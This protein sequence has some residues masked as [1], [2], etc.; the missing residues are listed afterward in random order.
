MISLAPLQVLLFRHPDDDEL[1]PFENA[2]VRAFQ[3][4]KEAGGYLASGDD[5]AV[6]LSPFGAAPT[7]PAD[8]MLDDFCHTLVIV[9]VD[10]HMLDATSA[11]SVLAWLGACWT[12]CRASRGRHAMFVLPMEER[13]VAELARREPVLGSLQIRAAHE[14]GERAVR[15]AMFALRVLHESRV[16]LARAMSVVADAGAEPGFLRLFIS[17]AKLDG[18]PL[19]QALKSY[20]N[21]TGWLHK[22]YDAEDLPP[23]CD[24]QAE[25]ERGVGTSVIVMLRT[26]EYDG[27]YWCQQEVLWADTYATPAVLVD[28]RTSLQH[29]AA[30]LPFDRVPIVR[31]PDG[32]LTRVLYA[33]LREGLRFLLFA[34]RVEELRRVGVIPIP[35]E[36]RVFSLPP[37]MPALLRVCQSWSSTAVHAATPRLIV[38]PDPPLRVGVYEAA[39]ALVA[40]TAPGARL[41]TPNTLAAT[42]GLV[43]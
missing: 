12:H 29:S 34:R 32:N 17:H 33:A 26:E 3:G 37:S 30:S 21:L 16:L 42:G 11:A 1:L 20:I 8:E 28:A 7:R 2:V 5:L 23:G 9:L 40:A 35:A 36:L 41:V 15:H 27:R 14:L 13:Q 4:G 6:Q 38:Y 31:I 24:W 10:R 22:F 19:A 43:P 25:L 39:V 18:L